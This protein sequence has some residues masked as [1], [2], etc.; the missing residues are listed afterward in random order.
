MMI[1]YER[2]SLFIRV[3]ILFYIVLADIIFLAIS[4]SQAKSFK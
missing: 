4:P 1:I 3:L 2:I